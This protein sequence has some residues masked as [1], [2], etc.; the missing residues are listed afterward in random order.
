MTALILLAAAAALGAPGGLV[1]LD[2]T[3]PRRHSLSA[4]D[5][6]RCHTDEAADWAASRHRVAFTNAVFTASWRAW[7]NGWCLSCHLPLASA[8][9]LVTG[10]GAP[11][12][13]GAFHAAALSETPTDGLVAEGVSCAVCH[14]RDGA[15]VTASTP[16]LLS[17]AFHR[18]EQDPTLG[19]SAFCGQ[20]HAFPFQRHTPAWPFSLGDEPA[21]DTLAEWQRSAA[22]A[23]GLTCQ[24]CHMP[25]GKHSFA[26]AHDTGLLRQTLSAEVW[27]EGDG[28]A[29]RVTATGAAHRVPTG[30][31]FRRL[32]LWLCADAACDERTARA[33][34]MR[35]FEATDTSW[36]LVEDRAVPAATDGPTAH[37]ELRLQPDG[38]ARY[39]K[40]WLYYGDARLHDQLTEPDIRALVT[41]GP[42]AAEP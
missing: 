17:K 37:R 31:P 38:E 30:D 20:C 15:V 19:E 16:S 21:Q 36:A 14:L 6:A 22:A 8:Q 29:A 18:V 34:L 11:A 28:V 9:A 10:T 7:P 27:R 41:E 42:V 24:S 5:C 23:E 4:E 1:A 32:E 3:P 26:G 35:I 40:L 2:P 13:P 12:V 33:S 39:Y 25:E